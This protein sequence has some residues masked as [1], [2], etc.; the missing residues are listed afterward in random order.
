[1]V[2][3]SIFREFTDKHGATSAGKMGLFTNGYVFAKDESVELYDVSFNKSVDTYAIN[4]I[5]NEKFKIKIVYE[6]I[7]GIKYKYD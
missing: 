5:L 1:M 6:C 7:Y 4:L 2:F 3:S